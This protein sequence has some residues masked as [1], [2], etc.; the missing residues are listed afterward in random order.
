MG[1]I[2]LILRNIGPTEAAVADELRAT[3]KRLVVYDV[4]GD[5]IRGGYR[6]P[7]WMKGAQLGRSSVARNRFEQLM[8][9]RDIEHVLAS[10]M[11]ACA[12]AAHILMR[13][14]VPLLWPTD[15]DYSSKRTTLVHGFEQMMRVTDRLLLPDD[16]E[17]DKA[18][19]K[20]STLPHLRLPLPQVV[21]REY[22][23]T[24]PEPRVAL[25]H[26]TGEAPAAVEFALT[27]SEEADVPVETMDKVLQWC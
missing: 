21:E 15:L 4:S 3:G 24:H 22:L 13:D 23:G 5:F 2:L 17:M 19:S 27:L 8:Q 16:F 14:F 6:Q 11:D 9:Q 7:I 26:P 25:I 18:L 10:G 20:G 12:F 1:E